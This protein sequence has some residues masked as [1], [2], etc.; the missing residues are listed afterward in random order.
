[1]EAVTTLVDSLVTVDS[2]LER[3]VLL[4]HFHSLRHHLA[5]D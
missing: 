5:R 2:V 1:M 4:E 3:L